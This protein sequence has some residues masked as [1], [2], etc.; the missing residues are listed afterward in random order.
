MHAE[1]YTLE[2]AVVVASPVAAAV[3]ASSAGVVDV[4]WSAVEA[5]EAQ[6][7]GLCRPVRV[8]P[9]AEVLPARLCKAG[10]SAAK[11]H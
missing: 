11:D 8:H 1:E 9:E 10:L 7:A 3:A 6:A 4:D 5:V 2:V